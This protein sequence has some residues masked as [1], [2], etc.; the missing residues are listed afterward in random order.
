M[1]A[2]IWTKYGPPEVLQLGEV[3]MP[4]PRADEVRI[5][6]HATTAFAGDVE[7]RTLKIG[8]AFALPM[9]LYAGVIKPTRI[10]ILGQELAGEIDAVGEDVTAFA[11][12]DPVYAAT[13]FRFGA[14]AEYAC[15]PEKGALAMK[16][17]NMTYAEAAAVPVG[18]Q[19]ALFF[20]RQ[21]RIK[22]GEQVLINGAG[23]SIGTFSVQLAKYYGAEVTGVD[24]PEKLDLLREIG[25]TQ[26]I[27]YTT[28]D[29]TKREGTYD[30]IFDVMGKSSFAGAMRALKPGGRY[31]IGNAGPVKQFRGRW[32]GKREGKQVFTGTAD[33]NREGLE[34]LRELIEAGHLKTIIDRT[35]PLEQMAAAHRYVET[36]QK[37]GHVVITVT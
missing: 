25:A 29:F 27:D 31:L 17:A 3:E 26:V 2:I 37:K 9:R 16:P 33:L 15:L 32:A 35:Y 4:I 28:E 34:A 24:K 5:K 14:Y 11:V 18:G 7:M 6:I 36:G 21:A 19:E 1:K 20:M 13:G 12:G 10:T 23:G 30:V 22:P 8:L